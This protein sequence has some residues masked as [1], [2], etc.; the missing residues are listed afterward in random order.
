[1]SIGFDLWSNMLR[2][3]RAKVVGGVLLLTALVVLVHY[4]DL[5]RYVSSESLRSVMEAHGMLAPLV[6]IGLYAVATI[7]VVPGSALT[8]AG[9]VLFGPLF[10]TVYTVAGASLGAA[11]AFFFARFVRGGRALVGAG[12]WTTLLA[13]YD[14]RI[15]A[16]GFITVLFLRLVPLFPF[17][18]LNYGLG[19]T[20]VRVR[21]YLVGT[22][23][24]IIPGTFAYTYF[25]NALASFRLQPII[26]AAIL[27][28]IITLIGRYILKRYGQPGN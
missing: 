22:M 9:G 14:A 23:I 6:Y 20:S 19:F 26:G 27:I 4:F 13:S 10:G 15:K 8:L 17:S 16:N 1:M 5:V 3:T 12:R 25:G 2:Y 18:A 21:D 11:F 28:V 7:A 24:G